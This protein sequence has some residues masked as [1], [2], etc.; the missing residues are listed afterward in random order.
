MLDLAQMKVC[1]V[2]PTVSK[3]F[4]YFYSM[5]PNY[6]APAAAPFS[7]A[8]FLQD[9]AIHKALF[10]PVENKV[11]RGIKKPVTQQIAQFS[12]QV[13]KRYANVFNN[14]MMPII[15][16]FGS[17]YPIISSPSSTPQKPVAGQSSNPVTPPQP[18]VQ[19]QAVQPAQNQPANQAPLVL[20]PAQQGQQASQVT[21]PAN[22]QSQ[23]AQQSPP[24]ANQPAKQS[25]APQPAP[26]NT[27]Q[28]PAN[29]P[30]GITPT[31]PIPPP[32]PATV[33]TKLPPPACPLMLPAPIGPAQKLPAMMYTVRIDP[34]HKRAIPSSDDV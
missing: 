7:V 21:A 10:H 33:P 8:T 6:N 14:F 16:G 26:A 20:Q 34:R 17:V 32:V 15:D 12:S 5:A 23:P 25:S 30:V 28:Q 31:T 3:Q 29:N 27:T 1:D 4:I 22:T 13:Y 19:Q 2:Q 24:P 9:Y 11:T 18:A